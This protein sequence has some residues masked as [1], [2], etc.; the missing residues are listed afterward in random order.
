MSVRLT[1]LRSSSSYPVTVRGIVY[2]LREK[3]L[4]SFILR[5]LR[6]RKIYSDLKLGK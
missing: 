4:I 5:R 3:V 1:L 2:S 6:D